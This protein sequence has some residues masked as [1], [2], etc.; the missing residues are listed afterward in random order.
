MV[1]FVV[2]YAGVDGSGV[3]ISGDGGDTWKLLS[4]SP[5]EP[6]R[7]VITPSTHSLLVS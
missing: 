6:L 2:I 5:Q 7:A 1:R 4:G 3:Y